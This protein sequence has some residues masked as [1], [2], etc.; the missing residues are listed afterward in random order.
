MSQTRT[1]IFAKSIQIFKS[2]FVAFKHNKQ[3]FFIFD[4]HVM[5]RKN[6]KSR[7]HRRKMKLA[8][9]N[10]DMPGNL[11]LVLLINQVC[12]DCP[13]IDTTVTGEVS[14]SI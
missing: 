3:S 11:N 8:D 6:D 4:C 10:D 12:L 7:D 5:G 13:D 2:S 1:T 14:L 9:R